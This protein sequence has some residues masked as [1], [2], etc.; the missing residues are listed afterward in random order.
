[1]EDI[2]PVLD[3]RAATQRRDDFI[4]RLVPEFGAGWG[5]KVVLTQGAYNITQ[6]VVQSPQG[7]RRTM[8]MPLDVYLGVVAATNM[9]Q[10]T[11]KQTRILPRRP[12]EL[13]GGRNAEPAR[14]RPGLLREERRRRGRH[15]A[16]RASL[17]DAGLCAR[18]ASRPAGGDPPRPPTTDTWS[19]AQTQEEFYFSLPYAEMDLCLHGL[20]FGADVAEVAQAA[21]LS[22]EQVTCVFRDIGAKRRNAQYLHAGPLLVEGLKVDLT[23]AG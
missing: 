5:C 17:Q 10:R 18:R 3:A 22:T 20:N 16:D 7:E 13:R 8:R 12:A 4:R 2:A 6:L 15:Q 1:M 21:G 9:K 19:L 23:P 11:R 14:I